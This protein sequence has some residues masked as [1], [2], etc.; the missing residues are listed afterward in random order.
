MPENE[1]QG[2]E[3]LVDAAAVAAA[4][5]AG[6][7]DADKATAKAA[8]DAAAAKGAAPGLAFS[9]DEKGS[10]QVFGKAGEDGRPANI[11]PK[12]WDPDKKALKADVVF[13]QLRW[14]EG[15]LGKSLEIL[16][17]PPEGKDYEVVI[18][19]A[20][21]VQIAPEDPAVK[22]FLAI[23]RKHDVSQAFVN[24][25]MEAVATEVATVQG[26]TLDDEMKKL[27]K[28]GAAR[29]KN[30][31]DFL[32]ANV[33]PQQAKAVK[34]MVTSSTAFEAIESLIA[35]ASP[36][37][38]ASKEDQAASVSS[39]QSLKA[40]WEAKY[41]AVYDSGPNK[42]ERKMAVDKDYAKE[43]NALRDRVFGT[44]RRDASGRVVNG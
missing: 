40:E 44:D 9:Y 8:A 39:M 30:L 11:Q 35:K 13:N 43:V 22:G 3:N 31:E 36:P 25:V 20:L 10:E 4:A 1:A 27:G 16:G 2:N 15:K 26:A 23:A 24:E 42:G 41:F 28:D 18:P 17:A 7:T 37:K 21:N 34:A 19:E 38:F 32:T 5:A 33:D 12:Y 14:A 29:L 6:Q